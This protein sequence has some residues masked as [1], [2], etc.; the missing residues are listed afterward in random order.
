MS[1]NSFVMSIGGGEEGGR[2][3]GVADDIDVGAGASK[4]L[5]RK[6]INRSFNV[7]TE[8][9]LATLSR[10][11]S[12]KITGVLNSTLTAPTSTSMVGTIF[13]NKEVGVEDGCG[14]L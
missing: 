7:F 8:P 11:C 5:G 10:L 12:V 2:G 13:P 14:V 4:E 9:S 1:N 6:A 3:A